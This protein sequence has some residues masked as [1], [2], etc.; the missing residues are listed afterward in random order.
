MYYRIRKRWGMQDVLKTNPDVT[1]E[2]RSV[3]HGRAM[4][5]QR[6]FLVRIGYQYA[7]M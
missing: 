1:A 6:D 3:V 4:W 2:D 7:S 5:M